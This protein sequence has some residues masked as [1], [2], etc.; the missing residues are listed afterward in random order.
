MM[1]SSSLYG[2]Q[3]HGGNQ[4]IV[5][6]IRG[7]GGKRPSNNLK[8]GGSKLAYAMAEDDIIREE[9]KE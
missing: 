6:S 8:V 7:G 3:H 4:R 5:K 1:R 2:A 9:S